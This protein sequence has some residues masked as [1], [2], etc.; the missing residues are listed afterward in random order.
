MPIEMDAELYCESGGRKG[1]LCLLP[2]GTGG[3]GREGV[4][5][6]KE[7]PCDA[8]G[9]PFDVPRKPDI[10]AVAGWKTLPFN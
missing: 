3:A 4:R 2:V 8:D 6:P 7:P 1:S 9:A 10:V 5:D